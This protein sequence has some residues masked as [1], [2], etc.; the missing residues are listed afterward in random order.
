[1]KKV[2]NEGDAG[3]DYQDDADEED[4]ENGRHIEGVESRR[5]IVALP[6]EG[7]EVLDAGV[8]SSGCRE[9]PCE[10][11]RIQTVYCLDPN[12]FDLTVTPCPDS[13]H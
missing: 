9:K 10:D 3:D 13:E 12:E 4:G 11:N 6:S 5:E 7:N 8:D 2:V 1:M